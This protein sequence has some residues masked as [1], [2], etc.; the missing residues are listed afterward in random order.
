MVLLVV[1]AVCSIWYGS[2]SLRMVLRCLGSGGVSLSS[3]GSSL[4]RGA[5][6]VWL[7]GSLS[8]RLACL[9][10]ILGFA[11]RYGLAGLVPEVRLAASS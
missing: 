10:A 11:V 2:L 8:L 7:W 3:R 1:F 5:A 9:G 4:S 6:G